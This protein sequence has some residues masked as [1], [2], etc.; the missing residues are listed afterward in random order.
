M[1]FSF[2]TAEIF[3]LFDC[4]L[5]LFEDIDGD[6]S[7]IT[8]RPPPPTTGKDKDTHYGKMTVWHTKDLVI[9]WNSF[10]LNEGKNSLVP[11]WPL[12]PLVIN[13]LQ[14]TSDTHLL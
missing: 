1:F 6:P 11:W 2:S 5:G 9:P 10:L 3:G 12:W 4:F 7:R 14:M 13:H 8:L